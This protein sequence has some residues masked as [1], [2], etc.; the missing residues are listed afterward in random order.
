M[1]EIR[2]RIEATHVRDA[3]LPHTQVWKEWYR[4]DLIPADEVQAL[5]DEAVKAERERAAKVIEGASQ[6]RFSAMQV[7]HGGARLELMR[8]ASHLRA[9]ATVIRG[10]SSD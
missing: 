2:A 3:V 5:V 9:L 10:G 4:G 7:A 1:S 8:S 6:K